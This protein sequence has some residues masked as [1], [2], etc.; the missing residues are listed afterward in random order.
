MRESAT[1][2][3]TSR[4]SVADRALAHRVSSTPTPAFRPPQETVASWADA[5]AAYDAPELGPL[6]L[7]AGW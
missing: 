7:R 2:S 1:D 5:D 3:T 6:D 4:S